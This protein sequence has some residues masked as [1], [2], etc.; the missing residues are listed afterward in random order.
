MAL[1]EGP[2]LHGAWY[3]YV[4]S[5]WIYSTLAYKK[6]HVA[7]FSESGRSTREHLMDRAAGKLNS[8][9]HNGSPLLLRA[10]Q[11]P[12][13]TSLS[14]TF[15]DGPS[16]LH[17]VHVIPKMCLPLSNLPRF[18]TG[19]TPSRIKHQ[20]VL[21]PLPFAEALKYFSSPSQ[22]NTRHQ[23]ISASVCRSFLWGRY[24]RTNTFHPK[25]LKDLFQETGPTTTIFS[26]SWVEKAKKMCVKQ[27]HGA[28]DLVISSSISPTKLQ[29]RNYNFKMNKQKTRDIF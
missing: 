24:L 14:T 27:L 22:R 25:D 1:L 16:S 13:P 9:H 11:V 10:V 21:K 7:V 18:V 17:T 3:I 4:Y 28:R 8:S 12:H 15:G 26:Q 2:A 20:T 6:W 19:H 5:A 23:C 29:G